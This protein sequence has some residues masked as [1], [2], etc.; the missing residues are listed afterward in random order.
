VNWGAVIGDGEASCTEGKELGILWRG[1]SE[2][3]DCWVLGGG[4]EVMICRYDVGIV[5][6]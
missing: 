3:V 6:C 1:G 2:G 5:Y 4:K